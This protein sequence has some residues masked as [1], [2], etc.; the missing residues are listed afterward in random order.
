MFLPEEALFSR[1][2]CVTVRETSQNTKGVVLLRPMWV[3]LV[4]PASFALGACALK[5]VKSRD[6]AARLLHQQERSST[7]RVL[8][9]QLS[10][11]R[12]CT[13]KF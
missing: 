10:Y 1:L 5:E 11:A 9:L 8:R 6:C 4:Y 13:S 7:E 2:A 3:V 12:L